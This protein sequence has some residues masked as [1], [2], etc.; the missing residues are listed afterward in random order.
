MDPY[1]RERWSQFQSEMMK[2]CEVL[3]QIHQSLQSLKSEGADVVSGRNTLVKIC[4][5]GYG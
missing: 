1:V 5:L 4:F 2:E 3:S